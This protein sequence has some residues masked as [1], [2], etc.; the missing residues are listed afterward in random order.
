MCSCAF[1]SANHPGGATPRVLGRQLPP[2]PPQGAF[3]QQLVGGVV[4]VQDRGVAP[5]PP[6]GQ[7]SPDFCTVLHWMLTPSPNSFQHSLSPCHRLVWDSVP[8]EPTHLCLCHFSHLRVNAKNTNSESVTICS[9]TP[10]CLC[11]SACSAAL[12]SALVM[13]CRSCVG[14]TSR[15]SPSENHTSSLPPS[16]PPSVSGAV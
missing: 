8:R 11:C 4:G 15:K 2:P 12:S 3:G 13:D 7:P 6:R 9:G 5:P 10:G 1:G 14:T 16:L